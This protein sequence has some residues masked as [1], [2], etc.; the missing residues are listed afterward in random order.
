MY[1]ISLRFLN[2]RRRNR[3]RKKFKSIGMIE[4]ANILQINLSYFMKKIV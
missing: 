1:L 4:E 3:E 2:L